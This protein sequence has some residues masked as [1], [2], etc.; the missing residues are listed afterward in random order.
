MGKSKNSLDLLLVNIGG[1]GKKVYQEL[2]RDFSAIE[3][4]FWAALT[5]G[6]IRN[7]GYSVRILDAHARDLDIEETT[8]AIL[9]SQ[10]YLTNIVVYGQQPASSTQ[11]MYGA[12]LLCKEI[13]KE[14]KEAKIILTGLHPSVLP[15]RT[16]R[17][18]ECDFVGV[19]EGFYTLLGLLQKKDLSKIPGLWYRKG[20]NIFSNRRAEN[21]QDLE[22]ELSDVAW[23]LLP[24]DKYSAHNWHCLA[25]LDFRNGY[26]SIL[27]SLGCPFECKFCAIHAT[28]GERSV[29]YW[30]PEWVLGQIDILVK[31]YNVKNLKI[32]DELFILNPKHFIPICDGLIKRNYG[33]NIW[34][35][36]R[37][38]TIKEEYLDRLR[39][40]GFKWLCLGIESGSD[41]IRKSI[42]K[43]KFEKADIKNVVRKIKSAGINVMGNYMFGL[44]GDDLEGM[45]KTLDLAMKLNCEFV[46]F[47]STM[48]YPGSELYEEAIRKQI[49]LPGSWLGFSQHSYECLPQPTDKL[50][51]GEVLRFRDNAFNVYFTNPKYL[52]MVEQKFGVRA[53]RHIEKM[54]KIKL[55]RKL[56]GD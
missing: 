35:Y 18:E 19:G 22:S 30:S 42:C 21:I 34:V 52:N 43:G 29:R 12:G 41:E 31:K 26:A 28:F 2:A 32:I 33:L 9:S 51:A 3:P 40:A 5:A 47:Y 48:A 17:E 50:S 15:E 13:K 38:D 14:D 25:D 1:I 10:P 55:K 49:K 27:T 24:M 54:A 6:F 46:N 45:Q 8:K 11:L 36:A 53:R 37:V 56:L 44:P 39:Q 7:K 23:D 20:K 16:I 4:P